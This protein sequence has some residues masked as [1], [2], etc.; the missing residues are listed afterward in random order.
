MAWKSNLCC[1]IRLPC[2]GALCRAL[3]ML[4]RRAFYNGAGGEI[5]KMLHRTLWGLFFHK[6]VLVFYWPLT[7][8]SNLALAGCGEAVLVQIFF[9]SSHWKGFEFS[10]QRSFHVHFKQQTLKLISLEFLSLHDLTPM[11]HP[12]LFFALRRLRP[13]GD[14][15]LLSRCQSQPYPHCMPHTS[16]LIEQ[17]MHELVH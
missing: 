4:C 6:W 14:V 16:Y 15:N 8:N 1:E 13:R 12:A 7:L 3:C 11:K 17:K 9:S 5:T 10:G 2:S